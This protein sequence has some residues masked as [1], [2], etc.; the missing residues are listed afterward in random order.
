MAVPLFQ[1]MNVEAP[2]TV[3]QLWNSPALPGLSNSTT[4]KKVFVMPFLVEA[5]ENQQRSPTKRYSSAMAC[6]HE[7]AKLY[8]T[9]HYSRT[10]A[11]SMEVFAMYSSIMA[12]GNHREPSF[13]TSPCWYPSYTIL[14]SFMSQCRRLPMLF[15]GP[16]PNETLSTGRNDRAVAVLSSTLG[17][18]PAFRSS[19]LGKVDRRG[20][21]ICHG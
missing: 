17:D 12:R 18:N 15:I 21:V 3:S 11:S 20:F 8:L 6:M 9:H 4:K 14:Y 16:Q 5:R 13:Q 7:K 1:L 2:S 19:V 10:R